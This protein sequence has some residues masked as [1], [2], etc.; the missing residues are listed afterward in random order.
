MS[1]R[2]P[3]PT[4]EQV[5]VLF[6]AGHNAES[7]ELADHPHADEQGHF[8]GG[9]VL[10]VTRNKGDLTPVRALVGHGVAPETAAQML[11][12]MADLIEIAPDLVS[13]QPGTHVRRLPD[14]EILRDRL[15][16][17][18]I[19]AKLDQLPPD[20]R[21]RLVDSID[22]IRRALGE[23]GSRDKPKSD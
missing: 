6:L 22:Q 8:I 10:F 2:E 5:P 16:V 13:G 3:S 9:S 11:R 15:T 12:K 19:L 21:D 23:D 7:I 17:D 4:H 1:E 14:G 20:M 18:G